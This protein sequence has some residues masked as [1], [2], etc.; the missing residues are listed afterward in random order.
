[1]SVI[2]GVKDFLVGLIVITL[3]AI[4][5][6]LLYLLWPFIAVIGW[7]AIVLILIG[8][9]MLIGIGLIMIMGKAI[10]STYKKRD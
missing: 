1:M 8:I 10:R 9:A 4:L 6:I 7:L 5:I 2:E 3:S